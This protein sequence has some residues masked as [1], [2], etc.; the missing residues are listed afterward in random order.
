MAA[1]QPYA[2]SEPLRRWIDAAKSGVWKDLYVLPP[3]AFDVMDKALAAAHPFVFDFSEM[4][5][6]GNTTA[7]TQ[8]TADCITSGL[9]Q[10]PFDVT[11]LQW[12]EPPKGNW[13]YAAALIVTLRRDGCATEWGRMLQPLSDQ[14]QRNGRG[15]CVAAVFGF[16]V[17]STDKTIPN[18][19]LPACFQDLSIIQSWNNSGHTL[20]LI[21]GKPFRDPDLEHICALSI[22]SPGIPE[23]LDATKRDAGI[24]FRNVLYYMGVLSSRG[25]SARTIAPDPR[26][27]SKR[28][29]E[30]R[31]PWISYSL[32]SIPQYAGAIGTRSG[33]TVIGRQPPRQHWRRGHIRTL[34]SGKLTAVCPCLVGASELGKVIASYHISHAEH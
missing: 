14:Y 2:S 21:D 5:A 32:I 17:L 11:L 6:T 4:Q 24:T 16:G 15:T 25:P 26:V 10:P 20:P 18:D 33:A 19:L 31:S 13:R 23:A 34:A 28:L 12:P 22:F 29:R 1:Y 8:F 9:F 30:G 3:L 27:A 7:V